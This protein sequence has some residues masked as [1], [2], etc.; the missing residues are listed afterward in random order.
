M[1]TVLLAISLLAAGATSAPVSQTRSLENMLKDV[2]TSLV[3]DQ[4]Y[5]PGLKNEFVL[6]MNQAARLRFAE[7]DATIT[8]ALFRYEPAGLQV[9]YGFLSE[10]HTWVLAL[11]PERPV[12]WR[13]IGNNRAQLG[14][15]TE[16]HLRDGEA[17]V[18]FLAKRMSSAEVKETLHRMQEQRLKQLRQGL[19]WDEAGTVKP[20]QMMIPGRDDPDLTTLRT[21]YGLEEVV[22]GAGDDY[23]G[24]RRLV[25]WAH[26]RWQHNGDNTPSHSDPLT[27]L[28]EAA[29]GKQ[30]RCVE[31]ATVTVGCAQALGMPARIL[32]LKRKDVETAKNSAGHVVAEVWLDSRKKWVFVDGQWDAIPEKDGVPLN[33]VE[34]Q[35]AFAKD[36]PGL[37]I[38]SSSKVDAARYL[39]WIVP[40]LYY[41]DFNVDQR[42][43]GRG[44]DHSSNEQRYQPKSGKIMLV[45]KGAKKPTVF[46]RT[47]PIRNCTYISSAKA[48]YPA[49]VSLP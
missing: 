5:V 39:L 33:A 37:R 21:K 40:Y 10:P 9:L 36:A 27:I 25:K 41:F 22:A 47:A 38:R 2:R 8:E 43:F 26:E 13:L 15:T 17:H 18:T 28:A 4:A 35:E 6:K 45:P 42:L 11:T 20:I 14:C 1:M 49:P 34:F 48:F 31:Y 19:E 30:F 24:L 12:D 16:L 29:E 3:V 23:E 44:S 7:N 32:S 46:Q